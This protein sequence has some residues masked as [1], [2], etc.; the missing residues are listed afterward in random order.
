MIARIQSTAYPANAKQLGVI[1][2]LPSRA[3]LTLLGKGFSSRT[4]K[5]RCQQAVYFVFLEDLDKDTQEEWA[6]AMSC[7]SSTP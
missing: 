7:G 5:V 4:V 3:K 2:R 6:A 1:V